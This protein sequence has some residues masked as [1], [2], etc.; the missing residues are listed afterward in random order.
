MALNKAGRAPDAGRGCSPAVGARGEPGRGPRAAGPG[1]PGGC[2]GHG[3]AGQGPGIG[4][5]GHLGHGGTAVFG[6]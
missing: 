4:A 6:V 1:L 5:R 3:T 2:W